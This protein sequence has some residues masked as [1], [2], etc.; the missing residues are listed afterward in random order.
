[1]S[2][3]KPR[4]CW[5]RLRRKNLAGKYETLPPKEATFHRF[6][7]DFMEFEAGPGNYPVA[8]VEDAYTLAV[9]VVPAEDI[10]FGTDPQFAKD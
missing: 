8:I 9:H 7:E 10:C 1:M 3:Q 5:Y 4:A 2:E 6:A